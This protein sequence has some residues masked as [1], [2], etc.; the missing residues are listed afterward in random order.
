V[1]LDNFSTPLEELI[2]ALAVVETH[3][4]F[5]GVVQ[6]HEAEEIENAIAL[7]DNQ[8][9]RR[10]LM[11]WYEAGADPVVLTNPDSDADALEIPSVC[12]ELS[13]ALKHG[14]DALKA[15]LEPL[16][17]EARWEA[18]CQWED[19]YPAELK[20]LEQVEPNWVVV[21]GLT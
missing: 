18:V 17:L 10:Q 7:S 14:I 6:G 15:I 3:Q 2:K 21:L 1:A 8:P 5:W 9:Q 11:A 13:Q 20:T 19:V 4:E 16:S 12:L